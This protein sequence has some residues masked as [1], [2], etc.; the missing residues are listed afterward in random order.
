MLALAIAAAMTLTT[1]SANAHTICT[2]VADA[3]SGHVITQQGDC[4]FRTTPASTF[5]IAISLMGF[6]SGF[7]KDAHTPTLPYRTGYPDWGGDA[8]RQPTDPS[9]W[10]KYSVVWFSQQVTQS[11]GMTRFANYTRAFAFGNA[12]VRGDSRHDGLTHAWI[13]SSLQ[14]S[15]LEQ[16]AFLTKVVNRT[17]PVSGHAYDMTS[18]ITE[19]ATLAGGWDTHG[20]TGTGFPANSDGSDDEAHGWGWFVGWATRNGKTLVF[21][22]LI[23]DDAATPGQKPVG[24]RARDAFV[25]EFPSIAALAETKKP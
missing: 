1:P 25:A 18:Q 6:D 2:L 3:S 14:I 8:W 16:V 4:A 20:K 9:R 12:D 23:Q 19:V 5:K 13:D 7:L 10:I 15:P 22:R 24:L 21:A 11:L 17:L